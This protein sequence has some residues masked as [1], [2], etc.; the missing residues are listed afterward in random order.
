MDHH[1]CYERAHAARH[2][3]V[4]LPRVIV[5]HR[6]LLEEKTGLIARWRRAAPLACIVEVLLTIAPRPLQAQPLIPQTLSR[7]RRRR[8]PGP[9]G[10][11]PA[12][13]ERRIMHGRCP[14]DRSAWWIWSTCLFRHGHDT[15]VVRA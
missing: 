7:V 8:P 9:G 4:A 12:R 10:Y 14:V 13:N 6:C 15:K 5:A 2:Q 1:D 11:T 3:A